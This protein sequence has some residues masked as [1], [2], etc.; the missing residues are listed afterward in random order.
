MTDPILFPS[1]HD[2]ATKEALLGNNTIGGVKRGRQSSE[3][4]K[5]DVL[6]ESKEKKTLYRSYDHEEHG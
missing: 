3:K 4:K 6:G 2:A 5:G 1:G